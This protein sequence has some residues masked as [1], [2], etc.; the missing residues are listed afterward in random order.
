MLEGDYMDTIKGGIA[1]GLF[2]FVILLIIMRVMKIYTDVADIIGGK[3]ISF[4][5]DIFRKN[6]RTYR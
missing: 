1:L 5:R 2:F 4:L 6:K 3:I